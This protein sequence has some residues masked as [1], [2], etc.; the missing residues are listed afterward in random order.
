M[1]YAER[2]SLA[3]TLSDNGFDL[4]WRLALSWMEQTVQGLLALHKHN[5][6]ILHRDLKSLNLLVAYDFSIKLCDFGLSR[7]ATA[8]NYATL[9]Q[10]RGTYA[11]VAPDA[12]LGLPYTERSDVYSVGII[13][14]EIIHRL[15]TRKYARPFA[16]FEQIKM[17]FQIIL[18][19][20][21]KDT[22][23]PTIPPSCPAAVRNM[24]RLCLLRSA[25]ARPSC[26]DLLGHIAEIL[27]AYR[28]APAEF[29]NC[30]APATVAV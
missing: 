1:E 23:R 12:F 21:A 19:V 11:Y 25:E 26:E 15:L 27:E 20:A 29:D 9:Q 10:L 28:R 18:N 7:F 17:D 3:H 5:P 6:P 14:W 8:A 24:I 16:E 30:I 2:G 4:T 13:F 22:F